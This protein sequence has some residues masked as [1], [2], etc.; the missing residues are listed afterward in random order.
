MIPQVKLN[1]IKV[2]G[3]ESIVTPK[4]IFPIII[5]AFHN[6]NL[7]LLFERF[8]SKSIELNDELFSF[9]EAINSCESTY[10]NI[11]HLIRIL[12]YVYL[13]S[14]FISDVS[15]AKWFNNLSSLIFI[16]DLNLIQS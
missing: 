3:R 14:L 4:A 2:L 10:K 13:L 8:E 9:F 15:L 16:N 5:L 7:V 6:D 11:R 12:F 1:E